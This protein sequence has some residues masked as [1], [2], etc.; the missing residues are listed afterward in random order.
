MR[1]TRKR[2]S[3]AEKRMPPAEAMPMPLESSLP[4]PPARARGS[5]P[6]TAARVTIRTGRKESS[7]ARNRASRAPSAGASRRRTSIRS[8]TRIALLTT[9]PTSMTA[10]S[11]TKMFMLSPVAKRAQSTP[12]RPRGTVVRISRGHLKDS[13]MADRA[14]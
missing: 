9:I 7:M 8:I 5:I 11:M 3:R 10:P 14:R 6:R 4:S 12:I 13:M 1:G 2:A